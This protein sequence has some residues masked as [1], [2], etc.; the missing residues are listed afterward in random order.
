MRKQKKFQIAKT[1][2]PPYLSKSGFFILSFNVLYVKACN[3]CTIP[4]LPFPLSPPPPLVHP[5]SVVDPDPNWI[6]IRHSD[7]CGSGQE[8]IG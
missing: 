6:R 1:A 5:F 2:I 3:C 7:L 8:N 4:F